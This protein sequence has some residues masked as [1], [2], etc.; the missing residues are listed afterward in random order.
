MRLSDGHVLLELSHGPA[1]AWESQKRWVAVSRKPFWPPVTVA[2][3]V[4]TIDAH[5]GKDSS[6]TRLKLEIVMVVMADRLTMKSVDFSGLHVVRCRIL[7]LDVIS[8]LC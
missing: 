2:A 5:H 1:E 6:E 8:S 4:G 7:V 3:P